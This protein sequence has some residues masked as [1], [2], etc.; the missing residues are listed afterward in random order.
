MAARFGRLYT[1][2]PLGNQ[3]THLLGISCYE[4]QPI[5]D[6]VLTAVANA[7]GQRMNELRQQYPSRTIGCVLTAHQQ[8]PGIIAVSIVMGTIET[9]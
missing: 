5:E 4:R 2:E 8:D 9:E 3:R 6:Y 7:F 1:S